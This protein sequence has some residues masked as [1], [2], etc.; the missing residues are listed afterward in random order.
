MAKQYE[1]ILINGKDYPCR[2]GMAALM[3]YTKKTDT[4]IN[5]LGNLGNDMTMEQAITL[6]WCG[7]KDGAR[8][9]KKPFD[10]EPVDIADL[11]DDDAQAIE[12]IMEVFANQFNT[13]TDDEGNAIADKKVRKN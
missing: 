2:F 10:M 4:K 9:A 12:K 8:K 1:I 5:D 3:D 7:L 13:E 6:C 11:M